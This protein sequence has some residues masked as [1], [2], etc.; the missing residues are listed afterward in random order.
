MAS[1]HIIVHVAGTQAGKV[2]ID[3]HPIFLPPLV[4]EDNA[5]I[6]PHHFC[7]L[8][9]RKAGE[10]LWLDES[11]KLVEAENHGSVLKLGKDLG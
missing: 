2:E 11:G 6:I 7:V 1:N 5:L 9:I 10:F 8:R 4:H 3:V